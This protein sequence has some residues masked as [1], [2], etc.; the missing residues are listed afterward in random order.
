[1]ESF[2]NLW[3]EVKKKVL[4]LSNFLV[5]MGNRFTDPI[6]KWLAYDCITDVDNPLTRHLLDITLVRDVLWNS[7]IFACKLKDVLDGQ[8]FVL[9]ACKILDV[10]TLE[11][12]LLLNTKVYSIKMSWESATSFELVTFT[13]LSKSI[14]SG[15]LSYKDKLCNQLWGTSRS[16]S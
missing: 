13:Y 15:C 7:C 1:M 5:P 3:I 4:L 9:W 11:E 2:E 12:E 14:W 10:I 16:R 6:C 8:S